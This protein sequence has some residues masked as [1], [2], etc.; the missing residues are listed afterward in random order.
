MD[1]VKSWELNILAGK[2][3]ISVNRE[4]KII[5]HVIKCKQN[6]TIRHPC[7]VPSLQQSQGLQ[8]WRHRCLPH[9]FFPQKF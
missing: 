5:L 6:K 3:Q 7:P 2:C 1:E 9:D 8:Q 4:K